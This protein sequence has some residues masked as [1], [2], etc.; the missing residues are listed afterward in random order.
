MPRVILVDEDDNPVGTEEKLNAHQNGGK[1]HRCF[2]IFVFNDKGEMMLQKR[3]DGKYH[4]GGLWTNTCCSHPKP[5][6]DVEDAAHRRIQEEMGFDCS[7]EEVF[8]FQYK[9]DF[10]NGLTE[11][12]M[13]HT[14]IGRYNKDP[15]PNS[16]EVGDWKWIKINDLKKDIQKNPD[17]D[18][19]WFKIAVE[20]VLKHR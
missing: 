3:A 10:D 20:K 6:E 11:H 7:M 4:C 17:K 12:E 18:T 15:N 9:A 2:S 8:V 14:F 1:L 16:E 5:S 19:P 13:D